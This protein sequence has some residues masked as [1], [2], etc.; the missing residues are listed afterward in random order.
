MR[1]RDLFGIGVLC[2]LLAACAPKQLIR[3]DVSPQPATLYLNGKALETIPSALELRSDRAHVLYFKSEGYRPERV[4]LESHEVGG[5]PLL[6]PAEVKV[7][8]LPAGRV[9]RDLTIEL[10]RE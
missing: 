7:R 10:D 6:A 5:E 2:V 8:M 4:V 1:R 3:L 9:G